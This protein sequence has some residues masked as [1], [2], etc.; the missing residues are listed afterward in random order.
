MLGNPLPQPSGNGSISVPDAYAR[1]INAVLPRVLALFDVD[2]ISATRGFGDR[3]YWSWKLIDYANATPQGMVHGLALLAAS[4]RLP[5]NI[6]RSS[7]IARIDAAIEAAGRQRASD[8]SLV[9]AFPNEKSF[10]VTALI[11]FDILC[12][13]DALEAHID[14]ATEARWRS[15]VAP[16][17]AFLMKYDE[18]HAMIS[19]HLATAAAALSRWAENGDGAA[20]RRS[21]EI[22]AV[23]LRHQSG[24][25]WFMEYDGADPGYE[26]LGLSYLADV[27]QRRPSA[28]LGAAIGRSL[29]FLTYAAHPDGSFGGIYGSRNTRFIYPAGLEILAGS[30][31]AAAALADFARRSIETRAVPTLSTMDDSNLAPMFNAY[32]R[33]LSAPTAMTS[34]SSA[35]LPSRSNNYWRK[36]LPESGLIIDNGPEHYTV[37]STM[38]G[39]VVYHFRKDQPGKSL[40]DTGVAAEIGGRMFTTQAADRSNNVNLTGDKLVIESSLVAAI[41]EQQTPF[42]MIV[43]RLLC[44]SLFRSR[45]VLEIVKRM[46]VR[47]LITDR[48]AAPL[49]NRRTIALGSRLSIDDDIS[50]TVSFKRISASRPFKAIHMASSGYWQIG[51]DTK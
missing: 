21:S 37:V 33:A 36:T 29:Q 10:C 42:K 30:F 18:T 49:R 19:N 7:I 26:T 8:G 24:E 43:L 4:N 50:G 51:D 11:A 28:D 23:I 47:R 17:I 32:C 44:L 22:V 35:T 41:S 34:S 5:W 38:K 31:P 13:T 1:E 45:A 39:G 14:P 16:M 12:A 25:G 48:R 15:I 40:V 3:L 9:E 6:D 2:A 46:L 27:H 20:A